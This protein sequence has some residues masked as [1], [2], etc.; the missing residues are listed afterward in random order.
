MRALG[1]DVNKHDV[2]EIM[3]QYDKI[4]SGQIDYSDFLDISL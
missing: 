1:F 3:K 2:M 4:G